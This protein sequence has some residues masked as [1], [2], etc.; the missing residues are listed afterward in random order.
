MFICGLNKYK[1]YISNRDEKAVITRDDCVIYKKAA[2]QTPWIKANP[3]CEE[4]MAGDLA[5]DNGYE[6]QRDMSELELF[7]EMLKIIT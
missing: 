4:F 3:M 7:A 1:L 6:Y 5:L 2:P